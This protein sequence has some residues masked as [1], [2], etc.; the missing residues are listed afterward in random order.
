MPETGILRRRAALALAPLVSLALY[1]RTI[2]FG[3]V[4]DDNAYLQPGVAYTDWASLWHWAFAPFFLYFRP[5][6]LLTMGA[7]QI[8]GGGAMWPHLTSVLLMTVNSLMVAILAAFCVQRRNPAAPA[9][10][11]GAGA[12]AVYAAHPAM[13]ESVA[14]ISCRFDLMATF[15]VLGALVADRTL[16]RPGVRI[17]ALGLCQFLALMSKEAALPL[18]LILPVWQYLFAE[19][20]PYDWRHRKFEY[21]GLVA[22]TGAYMAVRAASMP[23]FLPQLA[24]TSSS[25]SL[26]EHAA[27]ILTALRDYAVRTL[28]PWLSAGPVHFFVPPAQL[29]DAKSLGG[30]FMLAVGGAAAWR[31]RNTQRL[32]LLLLLCAGLALSPAT[33]IIPLHLQESTIQDRF[34]TLP[35][36][37]LCM[38]LAVLV[39]TLFGEGNSEARRRLVLGGLGL[40]GLALAASTFITVPMWRDNM[41]LFS[42]VLQRWP[43]SQIAG[44]NLLRAMLDQKDYEGA[45]TFAE[46]LFQFHNGQ[47]TTTQWL[48]YEEALTALQQPQL[49]LKALGRAAASVE[50]GDR[51]SMAKIFYRSGKIF[52]NQ[53]DLVNAQA[54]LN[55]SVSNSPDYPEAN[56]FLAVALLAGGKAQEGRERL[57]KAYTLAYPALAEEERA[58]ID[59]HVKAA[60]SASQP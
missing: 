39:A 12:G 50:P 26:S 21:A 31:L 27:L 7:E 37:F 14:W 59:E 40:W 22:A 9:W 1:W 42:S 33:H 38:A 49:A 30:L 18:I 36:S 5:L 17:V 48:G 25:A 44:G 34:L 8:L 10:I 45:R 11:I 32:P 58:S 19:T 46:K 35:L 57:E 41:S 28:L 51:S 54:H 15:F 4:W 20:Q 52:L 13:V 16:H 43:Q 2:G 56:Y 55:R 23:D 6:P 53:G 24:T 3:L 60:R 47:L 29:T